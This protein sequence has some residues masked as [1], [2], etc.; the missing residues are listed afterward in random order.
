M[1]EKPLFPTM[2]YETQIPKDLSFA[3]L[4]EIK[5]KQQTIELVSEATQIIP[6]SDYATDFAHSIRIEHFWNDAVPFL[7]N[8][9]KQIGYRMENILSWVSCYTGPHGHHPL[10]NH[11]PGYSGRM[12]Y[13]AILYL[14]RTGMTDFFNTSVAARD[15]QYTNT[16]DVGSVIFFPSIIPHQYRSEQFDGQPRYTLPFNCE[17][18]SLTQL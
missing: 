7:Q 3:I 17:L 18:A 9:W 10:H 8:E 13:S 15:Y 16:H 6:V 12:H 5:Y 4:D 1:L 14:T 2:F 11:E